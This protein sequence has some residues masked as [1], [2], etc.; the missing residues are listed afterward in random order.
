MSVAR[1]RAATRRRLLLLQF[2]IAAVFVGFGAQLLRLQGFDAGAYAAQAEDAGTR[3]TQVPAERGE[4][5]DRNGV[6]LATSYDGV[7]LTADPALTAEKAPQI[8]GVLS[9]VLGDEVDYFDLI[10]TLRTPDSRFEYVAK[11]LPAWQAEAVLEALS[12]A[13]LNGVFVQHQN[14]RSYPNG[15]VAA[16]LLGRLNDE[17]EGVGGLEQAY[18]DELA[19]KDGSATYTVDP[20]TGQK[21]PLAESQAV[22][23]E[24]G[25]DVLTTIDSDLQWYADDRLAEAVTSVQADWGLAITMDVQTCEVLQM[26]QVPT[27]NADEQTNL[28]DDLTVSRAVQTVYEPGSVLKPVTMAALADLGKIEPT[29][30][31][32]VPSQ[33]TIDGFEIGDYWDHG[34]LRLTAAGVIADSSNLGTIIAAQQMDDD[35]MYGYLRKFGFGQATGVGLPGESSGLLADG[36]QWSRTNHATISFGQGISVTGMQVVRAIGAIAGGGQICEPTVV[37]GIRR[38]DGS[39][40]TVEQAEPQQIISQEAAR[41]ATTMM[42]AV[43]AEG[44]SAPNAG[45]SGYRVAGKTGTAWR[46]D[47]ETGRYVQGSNTV[48][49]IGFAPADAPRFVTYVVIDNPKAEATGGAT[50]GPVFRDIM[51]MALQRFGIAPT[52]APAPNTPQE[53]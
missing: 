6:A 52:G 44:G 4:I 40:T 50:T 33:M 31:I 35:T 38:P 32:E 25:G 14:L 27:F 29:T 37:S 30:P 48:S 12:E 22:P 34:T 9:Q 42:E 1:R 21:I 46:V 17:G 49:F 53:W 39:Q 41:S 47:P 18:D 43:V 28:T 24:P 2:L 10:D 5:L 23:M 8:A 11:E 7:T 51:S 45:I 26:S 16:N 15:S 36:S 13:D 19:G 3:S 20:T